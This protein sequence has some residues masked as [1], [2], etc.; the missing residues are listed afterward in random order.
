MNCAGTTIATD[1]AP[2]QAA[3]SSYHFYS[4]TTVAGNAPDAIRDVCSKKL[5]SPAGVVVVFLC[6]TLL[7]LI[8][9]S[10]GNLRK[11]SAL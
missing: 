1:M 4:F 10:P 6:D 3:F 9:I 7:V 5:S 11:N 8:K 2:E